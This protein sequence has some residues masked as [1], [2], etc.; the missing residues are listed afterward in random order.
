MIIAFDGNKYQC[1]GTYKTKERAL[2]ILDEIQK[3]LQPIYKITSEF[4]KSEMTGNCQWI[5]NQEYIP[6]QTKV[7][8]MPKE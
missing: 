1:L 3:L 7:Y 4:K 5:E 2:E 8:E 6:I